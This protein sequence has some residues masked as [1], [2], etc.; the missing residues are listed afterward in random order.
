MQHC[1]DI[2]DPYRRGL[3]PGGIIAVSYGGS[4]TGC[5]A[6]ALQRREARLQEKTMRGRRWTEQ[7]IVFSV[8]SFGGGGVVIGGRTLGF[9]GT[10]CRYNLRFGIVNTQ[11]L[12]LCVQLVKRPVT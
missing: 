3:T 2:R 9:S 12:I 10:Q 11:G 1:H 5:T 7:Q 6:G 4:V 8:C